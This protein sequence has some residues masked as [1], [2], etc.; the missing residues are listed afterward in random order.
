ML[1]YLFC[2]CFRKV[3][4]AAHLLLVGPE[5]GHFEVHEARGS[6]L[7]SRHVSVVV[8]LKRLHAMESPEIP[9]LQ[10]AGGHITSVGRV[11]DVGREAGGVRGLRESECACVLSSLRDT[12]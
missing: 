11:G 1:Q 6:R 3:Y 2:H 8:C 4:Q 12:P 10:Q 7:V 5:R 9:E